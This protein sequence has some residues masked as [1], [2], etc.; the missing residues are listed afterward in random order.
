M[1]QS[2]SWEAN[3][4]SPSQEISR[5]LWKPKVH[6]RIHKCSPPVPIL[7]Q[8]D[9]VHTPTSHFLKI[10]LIIILSSTPWSPHWSFFLRYPHQNP[11]HA[12]PSPIRSTFPAIP[13]NPFDF[14]TRT[15]LGEEQRPLS[16]S[17]CSYLHSPFT[18]SLL[19]PNILLSTLLSNTH[20]LHSS[21]IVS[22][23]VSN[24]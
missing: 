20:S 2:P 16:S 5:I 11:V 18:S 7:S 13:F 14:F 4:F 17:L 21:L 6:Y 9:P 10:Y 22:D 1:Q 19:G 3:R 24:Q 12:S 23:Q 8:L 15:T